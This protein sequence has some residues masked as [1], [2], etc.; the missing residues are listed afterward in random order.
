MPSNKITDKIS[1]ISPLKK[2]PFLLDRRCS[3]SPA[4]FSLLLGGHL[5]IYLTLESCKTVVFRGGILD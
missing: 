2:H 3:I 1:K 4:E 5:N